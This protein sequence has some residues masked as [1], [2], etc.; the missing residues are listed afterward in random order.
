MRLLMGFRKPFVP[1]EEAL[2]EAGCEFV[3]W[4]PGEPP[5][6][7]LRVDAALA[8]LCDLARRLRAAR[9]LRRALARARAPLVALDRDAPWHK[10]VPEWRLRLLRALG[11]P[12]VYA[13]HSLQDAPRFG[14]EALYL[15]NA[16]W[17]RHYGLG[18]RTLESLR[19]P[20]TYRY[21]VSFIGNLDAGRYR[22]HA[23]R[24]EFLQALRE[25][26]AALQVELQL[27]D[28]AG[29]APA[30]QVALIQASRINLNVG[31]AADHG[32]ERSW[33]LPERCYG[34]P[35]CGGFLLSDERRHASDDF[36][37]GREWAAFGA[38]ED[39]VAQIRRY[40]GAFEAARDI[41]EAAHRRVLREHTY[42]ERA[43][44]VLG[45]ITRW[46]ERLAPGAATP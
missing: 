44:R 40:L 42:A 43:R 25:R 2:L 11:V 45:C 22:E 1:L 12:H 3:R 23:R 15:P 9:T 14:G 20:S 7:P 28:A 46:R 8:D 38:L 34:I 17:T 39:C 26:L 41:A 33:G 13:S 35:A 6:A 4:L 29:L 19:E 5:P 27:F 21:S 18:S 31:A 37:P 30:E 24:V 10:G 36:V 16:A 32:A